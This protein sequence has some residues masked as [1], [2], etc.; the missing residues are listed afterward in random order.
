MRRG[1][2]IAAFNFSLDDQV[3]INGSRRDDNLITIDGA[4]GTR[5]RGNGSSIGVADADSTQEV[6]ILTGNYQPEYGRSSGGQIRIVTRGGTR[7][8]HGAFYEYFRN[9]D[10]NANTWSRNATVGSAVANNPAPFRFNQF[11]YNFSGPIYV[12]GV[13][14]NSDRNKFFFLF[15]Q[16]YVRFRQ[17]NT[18]FQKVP[19]VA[20]RGGDFSELLNPA[21]IYYG[22]VVTIKDP[23]TGLQYPNNIIP[24]SQLS[25]T[26]IGLLSAYPLP[27]ATQGANN[28]VADQSAPTDQRKDTGSFDYLPNQSH[29]IRFRVL[30]YDFISVTPFQ[31][32]YNLTP[33]IQSRPNQTASLSHT[34]TISP[35]FIN[36][37]LFTASVD[38]VKTVFDTSSGLA[39]RTKYGINYPYIF[40]GTKELANKIPTVNMSGVI[41]TLDGGPYPSHSGG[42]VTDL[43]DNITKI[44]GSHTIKAGFLWE[45]DGENDFDQINV[46]STTP[47]ATNNQ[48]GYFQ[49]TDGRTGAPTSGSALSN[50]ALGLFDTYGEIGQ[51]DY[52]LYRA[53]MYEW[54]VQ[55]SW[56]ATPRLRIEYGVRHTIIQPYYALWGNIAIFNPS[57]YVAANAPVVDPKTGFTSGGVPYNG[58]TIPGSGFPS[59]A[60]GRIP[61]A[62]TGQYSG[63]FHNTSPGYS[64]IDW[65][66]FQP[67]LGVAYST[68]SK[69]VVRAGV[70]RF[71]TR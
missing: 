27:N 50:A 13:H 44:L 19:S 4:V 28:W 58:I 51:K 2:S 67:R 55:D 24:K 15:G 18:A 65:A 9:S 25:P 68:G 36:E 32:T 23:T 61:G 70:G 48:N 54:F 29:S 60:A 35:T 22:K 69:T 49:F 12:P 45:R 46:S 43:S 33:Q 14:F 7:D 63:L 20:M 41:G 34:W 31:G 53:N 56:K 59:G 47:G 3:N 64:S 10:L 8:L 38:H 39:D 30:N 71:V 40:P 11:G 37:A 6:Q 62:A 66:D 1:N 5:T 42:L 57:H 17:D 52:T 21:N 16:E 26:G